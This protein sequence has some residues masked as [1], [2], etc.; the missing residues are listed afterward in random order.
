MPRVE[1]ADACRWCGG[2]GWVPFRIGDEKDVKDCLA[3][4]GT[5]REVD[6]RTDA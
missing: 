4:D 3:C 2:W 6:E 1:G 5:G